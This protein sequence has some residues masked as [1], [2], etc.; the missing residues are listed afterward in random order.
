MTQ[1]LPP[2]WTPLP[3][4]VVEY[5]PRWP[6]TFAELR[7]RL[8]AAVANRA[9]AIE[10]VGSTAVPGLAAKP[11]IDIDLVIRS[12]TELAAV[13]EGLTAIGYVHRGEL[14]NGPA[15]CDAFH[16]PHDSPVHHLYVCPQGN[17]AHRRH[18][19]LRD[20]P[21]AHPETAAE[22]AALKRELALR[23]STD[24]GGYTSAKTAFIERVL[25]RAL[26]EK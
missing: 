17:E 13:F 12:R 8:T 5:D 7:A 20:Y 23:Y 6:A 3:I 18:L 21:R 24:I 11:T 9:L 19:V 1:P 15:G 16:R 22:Y 4:E 26:R 25:A 2:P 14:Q 10:H